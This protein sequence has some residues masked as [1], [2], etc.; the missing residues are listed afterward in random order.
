MLSTDGFAET[1]DPDWMERR[2][3]ASAFRRPRRRRRS[4]VRSRAGFT[5][6]GIHTT[7]VEYKYSI[8]QMT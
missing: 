2:S 6:G 4:T 5:Q 1:W 8:V 3:R 7:T